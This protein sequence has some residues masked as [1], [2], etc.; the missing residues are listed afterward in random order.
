MARLDDLDMPA[1]GLDPANGVEPEVGAS[2]SDEH[3]VLDG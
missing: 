1:L 3:L 2:G